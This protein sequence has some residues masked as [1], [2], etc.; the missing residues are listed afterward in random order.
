[1][2]KLRFMLLFAP[3]AGRINE[4]RCQ[5]R[6]FP[7]LK[8]HR[9][10]RPCSEWNSRQFPNGRF[11]ISVC[12]GR[13]F[14]RIIHELKRSLRSHRRSKRSSNLGRRKKLPFSSFR[15]SRGAAGT[16]PMT[17]S[18][19]F[20]FSMTGSCRIGEKGNRNTRIQDTTTSSSRGSSLNGHDLW[21]SS[22]QSRLNAQIL[23]NAR[24]HT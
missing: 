1:M 16:F 21:S 2:N 22:N 14:V 6:R 19:F 13:E 24:S 20:N 7:A 17:I 10:S 8:I 12:S 23:F 5:R 18:T 11:L 4:Q 3:K 15:S 9:S